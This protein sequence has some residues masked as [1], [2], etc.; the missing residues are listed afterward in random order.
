MKVLRID[1]GTGVTLPHKKQFYGV[2]AIAMQEE[3][4]DGCKLELYGNLL[5]RNEPSLDILIGTGTLDGC[6]E[7][8]NSSWRRATVNTQPDH[9]VRSIR[10]RP[11][12]K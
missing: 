1:I 6:D 12:M 5:D 9:F 2:T 7:E 10:A 3:G 4:D 8:G 11:R